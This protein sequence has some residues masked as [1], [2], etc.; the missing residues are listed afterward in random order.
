MKKLKASTLV[1]VMVSILI[2]SI[3]LVAALA[4]YTAV[5]R[6]KHKDQMY[7]YFES[8]CLDIDKYY[9]KYGS[10]WCVYYYDVNQLE[11]DDAKS[12]YYSSD[13][14]VTTNTENY[15]YRLDYKYQDSNL[16]I[17]IYTLKDDLSTNKVV[18][19]NLVYGGN[20]NA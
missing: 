7:F 19:E 12:I 1:E 18:I 14:S 4:S 6:I 15:K 3:A 2:F 5:T 13:Y 17:N 10:L 9:S 20:R 8:I 16:V 11:K